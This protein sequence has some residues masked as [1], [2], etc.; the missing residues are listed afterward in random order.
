MSRKLPHYLRIERRRAGLSQTDIAA[1]LG[2]R[3]ASKISRYEHGRRLPP[4]KTA[5][6]YEAILGKPIAELFGGMSRVI[7]GE[8]QRRARSLEGSAARSPRGSRFFRRKESIKTI[9]AR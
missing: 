9:A 7:E 5:L 2:V 3:T 4:L 6:A 1:L 8:V